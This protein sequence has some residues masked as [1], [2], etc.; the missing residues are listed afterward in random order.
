MLNL[1]AARELRIRQL[2]RFVV[3]L[4]ICNESSLK[5]ELGYE[6]VVERRYTYK[7]FC[8]MNKKRP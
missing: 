6:D 8:V 5:S 3:T 4:D 1:S 7:D 2:Q